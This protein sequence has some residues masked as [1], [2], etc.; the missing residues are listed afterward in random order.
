MEDGLVLLQAVVGVARAVRSLYGPNKLRKQVTDEL[1]HTLFSADAYT[2]A[3][4]LQSQNAGTAILQQALDEQRRA[5]GTGCTTMLNLC[6]VLAEAVLELRRQGLQADTIQQALTSVEKTCLD[7]AKP[8]RISTEEAI[9]FFQKM[10][11]SRQLAALGR[12][13]STN[14]ERSIATSLAVRAASTLDPIEFCGGEGDLAL[15]NLVTT[16]VLLGGV[17]SATSS[18]VLEG[19]LL[20]IENSSLRRSLQSRCFPA[21][22][23]ING[24]VVVLDGNVELTDFVE[25]SS[26]QVI[27]V[28]GE[29]ST[30]ALDASASTPGAPMCVPVSSYKSL[31]HLA[32]MS[33]AEI[34]DSWDE[35]LPGAI[36]LECLEVKALDLTAVRAQ[37]DDDDD[38]VA[39]FFLQVVLPNARHQLHASVIVQ[40]PTRSLAT[41][42]RNDTHKMI[43]RLRNVLQSGYVLPGN[44]GFWCACAAAVVQEA[45]ALAKSNQELLSFATMR[46]AYPLSELSVILLENSGGCDPDTIEIESFFSRLAKVQ[47]VQ[48]KFARG[49]QD[50]GA[51][52][53]FSRYDFRSAEYAILSPKRTEPES[54][55]GRVFHVDEYKSMGS[56][57][58]GAFRVLQLLLNIDRHRVN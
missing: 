17:T 56:A 10:T 12:L 11:W 44:G 32:E 42:L 30:Q 3:S 5:F 53:F 45:E 18:R 2:V 21:V 50:I 38:E 13:L 33:G 40:G 15:E 55:D 8:M 7:T 46:L 4:A 37:D 14:G 39:S 34:I 6:G 58:R 27:F 41:E 23:I 1:E 26:I 36:G 22:M 20:P 48:K 57:I 31:R 24:G 16:H 54:E 47:T 9:P 49:V 35:L 29:I 19:V 25:N 28:H 52:K 51:N 43:C